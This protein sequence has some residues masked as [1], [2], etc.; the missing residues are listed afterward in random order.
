MFSSGPQQ[1]NEGGSLSYE[2]QIFYFL[3]DQLSMLFKTSNSFL[4][5]R[6]LFVGQNVSFCYSLKSQ[7]L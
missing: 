3:I 7:A 4:L 1:F 2:W 5:L 6:R